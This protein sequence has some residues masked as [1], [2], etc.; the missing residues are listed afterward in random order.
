MYIISSIPI[1]GE[2]SVT[3]DP[4]LPRPETSSTEKHTRP[5]DP[6]HGG[7]LFRLPREIRDKIYRLLL[8]GR[9]LAYNTPGS[10]LY[11]AK[12]K[13]GMSENPESHFSILRVSKLVGSEARDIMYS[14]SVFR[15]FVTI[16]NRWDDNARSKMKKLSTVAAMMNNVDI[17]I[18]APCF[19]RWE[20]FR[21]EGTDIYTETLREASRA[22]ADMFGGSCVKRQNLHIRFLGCENDMIRSNFSLDP[23][24]RNFGL[25]VGF[26][27]I[28]VE[29]MIRTTVLLHYT[30]HGR[31]KWTE[32]GHNLVRDITHAI[33]GYLEPTFG[34]AVSGFKSDIGGVCTPEGDVFSYRSTPLVGFLEFYP[35]KR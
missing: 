1:A 8:K 18:H 17:D 16:G 29:V 12:T 15:I 2:V 32:V 10:A 21:G 26:R 4:F 5:G 7:A 24:C 31:I 20:L 6:E 30:Q 9:Y 28:T 34:P 22:I 25:L 14:E 35:H 3:M 19:E 11:P 13:S 33:K 27:N 23:G